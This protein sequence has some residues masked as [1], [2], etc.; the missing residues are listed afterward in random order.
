MLGE[1]GETEERRMELQ[2]PMEK[3]EKEAN[4]KKISALIEEYRR[5]KDKNV[6]HFKF[7]ISGNSSSFGKLL[8]FPPYFRYLHL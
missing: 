8:L 6:Q 2:G 4:Q 1:D 7:N 3:R 5:F